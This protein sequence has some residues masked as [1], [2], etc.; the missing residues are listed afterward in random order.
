M[1]RQITKAQA[2][3]WRARWKAVNDA[4]RRELRNTPVAEKARQLAALMALAS[5]FP[6]TKIEME[7]EEAVR[8]R[9]NRL[10]KAARV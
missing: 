2:R 7:E 1:K 8:E 6:P 10:R 3:A 5:Q 4:E 9:W